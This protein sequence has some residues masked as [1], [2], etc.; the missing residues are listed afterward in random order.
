MAPTRDPTTQNRLASLRDLIIITGHYNNSRT[1]VPHIVTLTPSEY[2]YHPCIIS[3][4]EKPK[5]GP[6]VWPHFVA[7][8]RGPK[9]RPKKKQNQHFEGSFW[10][11]HYSKQNHSETIQRG[12][13]TIFFFQ[14]LSGFFI[15]LISGPVLY[16]LFKQLIIHNGSSITFAK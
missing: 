10:K 8:D 9:S 2:C 15:S 1:R 4:P 11:L 6:Q 12:I 5:S 3:R 14:S 7:P 16:I 13:F